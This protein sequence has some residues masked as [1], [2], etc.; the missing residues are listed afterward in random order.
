MGGFEHRSISELVKSFGPGM[1]TEFNKD[2]SLSTAFVNASIEYYEQ[3]LKEHRE[4][5]LEIQRLQARVDAD[6]EDLMAISSAIELIK[7]ALHKETK[8]E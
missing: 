5:V 8:A 4:R 7:K 1:A 2:I 3:K 6:H